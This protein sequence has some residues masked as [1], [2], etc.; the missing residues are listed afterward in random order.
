MIPLER[1]GDYT[2]G[3]ERINIEFSL[4]N[5][6]KL[7]ARL[8]ELLRSGDLPVRDELVGERKAQALEVVRA[9]ADALEV[10]ASIAWTIPRSSRTCSCTASASRGRRSCAI[11]F[12]TSSRGAISSR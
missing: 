5:K 10:G 2:D 12:A 4:A 8:E 3:I 9:T 1:L 6:L 11:R 7:C